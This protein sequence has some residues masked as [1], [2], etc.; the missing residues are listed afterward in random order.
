MKTKG[1]VLINVT[2]RDIV[3]GTFEIPSNITEIGEY[4]FASCTF[5]AKVI[6][7]NNVKKIGD[8]AFSMCYSLTDVVFEDGITTIGNYAFNGCERLIRIN[9][10]NS[11]RKIGSYAFYGC[12]SLT[13]I[14]LPNNIKDIGSFTFCDCLRLKSVVVSPNTVIDKNNF[15]G[16]PNV[17]IITDQVKKIVPTD[18]FNSIMSELQAHINNLKNLEIN[19]LNME[20]SMTIEK[21]GDELTSYSM[22]ISNGHYGAASIDK[23]TFKRN[24]NL[25][26]ILNQID[27]K[28][29]LLEKIG[30]SFLKE[31]EQ[32]IVLNKDAM[33]KLKNFASSEL[34]TYRKQVQILET[35]KEIIKLYVKKLDMCLEELNVIIQSDETD[36]FDKMDNNTLNND[37]G[38]KL[39]SI[40]LNR[41]NTLTIYNQINNAIATSMAYITSLKQV[42]EVLLPSVISEAAN[43][44]LVIRKQESVNAMKQIADILR[45]EVPKEIDIEEEPERNNVK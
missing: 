9:F 42:V 30:N 34:D 23:D 7:P 22:L 36:E 19:P 11:I 35:T 8:Y 21:F 32:D 45:N 41:T 17:K 4:A 25:R 40:Q 28:V 39:G 14:E 37:I 2:N 24:K 5:L 6:I 10:P 20:N 1:N 26:K 38:L 3:N 15:L 18:E 44:K 33:E 29:S 27:N 31:E 13:K 16:C 43:R 12:I